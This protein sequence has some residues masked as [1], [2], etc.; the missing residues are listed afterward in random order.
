MMHLFKEKKFDDLEFLA[1]RISDYGLHKLTQRK[2]TELLDFILKHIPK[3]EMIPAAMEHMFT[4][5][6]FLDHGW[7]LSDD[8]LLQYYETPAHYWYRSSV[9]YHLSV[10]P[11]TNIEVLKK[12]IKIAVER[13]DLDM[14]RELVRK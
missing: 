11:I 5:K 13:N 2:E 8:I 1:K 9:L 3:K 7:E 6:I 10:K 4:A 12:F 14:I